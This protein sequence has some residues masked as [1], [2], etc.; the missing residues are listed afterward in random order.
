MEKLKILQYILICSSFL[1]VTI[2]YI[3]IFLITIFIINIL[4]FISFSNQF[5]NL[6]NPCLNKWFHQN[7][8]ICLLVSSIRLVLEVKM[9]YECSVFQMHKGV[10]SFLFT[11]NKSQKN[12]FAKIQRHKLFIFQLLKIK[13][14]M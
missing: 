2:K 10:I 9:A 14:P 6:V 5:Y 8:T 13:F 1:Y 11:A 12:S 3:N 7:K 4:F